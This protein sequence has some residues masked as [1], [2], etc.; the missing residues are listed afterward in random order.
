MIKSYI[1][2]LF[3]LIFL[4]LPQSFA[5]VPT[6]ADKIQ[7]VGVFTTLGSK[8]DLN[9]TF[10]DSEGVTRPIRDFYLPEKPLVIMPVY[11]ECPSLC[12]IT[13]QS[14]IALI[15]DLEA[16]LGEDFNI[17]TVSFNPR[18]APKLAKR[19]SETI[20][21][22]LK[23]PEAAKKGWHFAVGTQE[24]INT[25]LGQLSYKLEVD[26]DDFSH[27]SA[28]FVLSPDGT[29]SQF[30]TGVNF[31]VW[32][33]KLSLVDASKGKVGNLLHQAALF[34]FQFDPIKGKY[35][36]TAMKAMRVAG[37]LT[38]VG[39]FIIWLCLVTKRKLRFKS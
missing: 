32:D 12:G 3:L 28:I 35:T 27:P 37:I 11:Y 30:F 7:N 8:V 31:P 6:A 26:G 13:I 18:E 38:L 2:P 1:I 21:K 9:T 17:L 5:Q 39:I 29:I 14:A 20:F 19:K 15:N 22:E 24:N 25:L 4:I 23:D 36:M 34:C 16:K 33:V 10:T